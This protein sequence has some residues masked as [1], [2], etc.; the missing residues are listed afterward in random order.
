MR[1][2]ANKTMN[3]SKHLVYRDYHYIDRASQA[4]LQ[5][6]QGEDYK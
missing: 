4:S 3:F 5:C 2:H 1:N 6:S